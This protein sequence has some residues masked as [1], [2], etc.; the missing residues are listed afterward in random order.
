MELW[1]ATVALSCQS[2]ARISLVRVELMTVTPA[3]GDGDGGE[4]RCEIALRPCSMGFSFLYDVSTLRTLPT[5]P[6]HRGA[7]AHR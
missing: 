2:D 7:A 3:N 6:L 5:Q 1:L 4:L